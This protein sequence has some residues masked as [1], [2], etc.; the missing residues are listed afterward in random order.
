MSINF[1]VDITNTSLTTEIGIITLFFFFVFGFIFIKN[2]KQSKRAKTISIIGITLTVIM[3]AWDVVMIDSPSHISFDE[4][5]SAWM[6]YGVICI[7]LF[8]LLLK[9]RNI[10]KEESSDIIDD[11]EFE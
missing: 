1:F 7:L 9:K 5:G 10:V 4:V 3:I 2:I 6:G 8:V 11:M